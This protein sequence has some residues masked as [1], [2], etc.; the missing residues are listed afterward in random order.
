[1]YLKIKLPK[2]IIR[3]ILRGNIIPSILV[4]KTIYF[5]ITKKKLYIFFP[6]NKMQFFILFSSKYFFIHSWNLARHMWLILTLLWLWML[7]YCDCL[8]GIWK[9]YMWLEVVESCSRLNSSFDN[10]VHC[11]IVNFLTHCSL[12]SI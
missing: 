3:S 2:K 10:D 11:R 8:E 12:R 6:K 4:Y 1:M 7:N 5:L 9:L